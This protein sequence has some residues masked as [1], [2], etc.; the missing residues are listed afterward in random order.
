[1]HAA[2]EDRV[3]PAEVVGRGRLMFSST[4]RTGQFSGSAAAMIS[5]PWGGM[6]A[7]TPT[8]G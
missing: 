1:M 5:S 8:S 6:K 3:G 2:D 7:C 4:K